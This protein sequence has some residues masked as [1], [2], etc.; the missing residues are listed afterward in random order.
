MNAEGQPRQS[1][2]R[3]WFLG[4]WRGETSL[5]VAYWRNNVLLAHV[6]PASLYKVYSTVGPLRSSLRWAASVS[7]LRKTFETHPHV[8]TVMLTSRGGRAAESEG[9]TTL[10]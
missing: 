3:N 10:G 1:T 2:T 4:H 7:D 9:R 8:D 5:G 6:V